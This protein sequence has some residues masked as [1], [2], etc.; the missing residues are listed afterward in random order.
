MVK[1]FYLE[2]GEREISL[3]TKTSRL[4]RIMWVGRDGFFWIQKSVV[5]SGY[6]TESGYCRYKKSEHPLVLRLPWKTLP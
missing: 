4:V 6:L 5:G 2:R 1:A 3:I